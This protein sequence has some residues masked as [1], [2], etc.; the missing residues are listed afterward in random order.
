MNANRLRLHPE[1]NLLPALGKLDEE[2]EELA[3]LRLKF[4]SIEMMTPNF[5][6]Q[7]NYLVVGAVVVVVL[8]LVPVLVL[9][10]VV[11]VLE[12]TEF[13][14]LAA[15]VGILDRR[16]LGDLGLGNQLEAVEVLLQPVDE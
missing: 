1:I 14:L 11:E 10:V 4:S 3:K 13:H 5:R 2:S 7:S 9:L 15:I 6:W 12:R 16:G 8:V